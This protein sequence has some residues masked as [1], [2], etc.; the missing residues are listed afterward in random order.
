MQQPGYNPPVYIQEPPSHAANPAYNIYMGRANQEI[1]PPQSGV[2]PG[3]KA[4]IRT[5]LDCIPFLR[6]DDERQGFVRKV[7]ALLFI[8][9]AITTIFVAA[10]AGSSAF[11]NFIYDH[12]WLYL[13]T[14]I[15][16]IVISL[17]LFCF[18]S[19]FKRVP[20]NY[21]LL[22]TFT[23]FESYSVAAITS[24][25]TPM[26]VLAAALLTL[27]M[28]LSL[29]LYACFTKTDATTWY[30]GLLWVFCGTMLVFVVFMIIY[31]SR[32]VFLIIA[33]VVVILVS[34]FIVVDTQIIIGGRR[35]GLGYDDYILAVM[36]L[37]TDLITLFVYVLALIGDRRN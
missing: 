17:A 21:I 2:Q 19:V 29:S 22:F 11:R 5:C 18:Y 3:Q 12:M 37:Y 20:I 4:P 6:G 9:L 35:Y 15:G 30:W 25:Y 34:I 28:A 26:S 24:A 13:L 10:A 31:P 36:L 32:Y 8:Q 27:V 33:F 16:A 14:T 7:Y 23:L 1:A